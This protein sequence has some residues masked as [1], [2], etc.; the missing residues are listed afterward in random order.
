MSELHELSLSLNDSLT[1]RSIRELAMSIPLNGRDV[2]FI[3]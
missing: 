3:T 2:T 1:L